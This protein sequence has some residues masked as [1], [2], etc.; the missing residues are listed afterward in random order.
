MV[1]SRGKQEK[2]CKLWTAGKTWRKFYVTES[3]SVFPTPSIVPVKRYYPLLKH[4]KLKREKIPLTD[5]NPRDCFSKSCRRLLTWPQ[6][7]FLLSFVL[8]PE[9]KDLIFGFSYQRWGP[10]GV[11]L[12]FFFFPSGML[13]PPPNNRSSFLSYFGPCEHKPALE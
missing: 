3:S 7:G 4:C 8:N 11:G 9:S 2:F 6:K 12:V 10:Y 13:F 5:T 1:L